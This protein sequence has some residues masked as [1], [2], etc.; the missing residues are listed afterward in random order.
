M[1]FTVSVVIVPEEVLVLNAN[2]PM[3]IPEIVP[4]VFLAPAKSLGVI[5]VLLLI[6]VLP[7]FHY[8]TQSRRLASTPAAPVSPFL[9]LDHTK[10]S[11]YIVLEIVMGISILP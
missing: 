11:L 10:E 1:P 7:V 4:S 6:S 2:E 8:L 3:A 9:A 5:T